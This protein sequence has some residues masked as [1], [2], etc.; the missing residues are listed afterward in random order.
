L[1]GRDDYR[2]DVDAGVALA[3]VALTLD[4][5]IGA[6]NVDAMFANDSGDHR[7][8]LKDANVADTAAFHEPYSGAV[9][10]LAKKLS[11]AGALVLRR[12]TLMTAAVTAMPAATLKARLEPLSGKARNRMATLAAPKV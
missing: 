4:L 3:A 6:A 12:E 1:F 8:A 7:A 5:P 11:H 2:G 10:R 9:E